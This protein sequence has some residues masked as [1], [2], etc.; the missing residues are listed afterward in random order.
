MLISGAIQIVPFSDKILYEDNDGDGIPNKDDPYPDEPF[1]DRFMI[2]DDYNYEPTVDF[3]DEHYE[4]SKECYDRLNINDT[5][6]A[7]IH[8]AH[9][10]MVLSHYAYKNDDSKIDEW[11]SSI[12]DVVNGHEVDFGT[13]VERS[14][15]SNALEHASV[16]LYH[17]FD[18]SGFPLHYSQEDTC[19]LISSSINNIDHLHRNLSYL[20]ECSEQTL[21][22]N[23]S[24]VLT[25]K[26]DAGIKAICFDDKGIDEGGSVCDI[27]N[28]RIDPSLIAD[29]IGFH[30]YPSGTYCNYVHRDWQ[31]TV[32]EAF[33]SVV[34]E[35]VR[36]GNQYI[37]KY[38]Y[39]FIDI[40]EWAL[41]YESG[42]PPSDV[43]SLHYFHEAGL[44]KEY[45]MEGCFEG[46]ITWEVGD[47]AYSPNVALQIENT[48]KK[49][50]NYQSW[51]D[52]NEYERFYNNV[53]K[54]YDKKYILGGKYK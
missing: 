11:I 51:Q 6:V 22:D 46:K 2:V 7:D 28:D 15:N 10:W 13:H 5:S 29:H 9:A 45:L 4:N 54:H 39:S 42:F 33:G 12:L 30:M 31:N 50:Q 40:Y 8:L 16:A 48:L 19:Q 49:L 23:S 38:R 32:G 53:K 14:K 20:M 26:N 3:V 52:S 36:N 1:D 34:A 25:V 21:S 41:H 17:Y 37:M 44:A 27:V 24:I 47:T 18:K 43:S 35:V